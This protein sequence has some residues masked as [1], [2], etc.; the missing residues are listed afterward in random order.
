MD[1]AKTEKLHMCSMLT[2]RRTDDSP[3]P[4]GLVL[5]DNVLTFPSPVPADSGD[6]ICFSGSASITYSLVIQDPPTTSPT[7]STLPVDEG[8]QGRIWHPPSRLHDYCV[9]YMVWL[10]KLG[11]FTYRLI[12]LSQLQL[13]STGDSMKNCSQCCHDWQPEGFC[14]PSDIQRVR[15]VLQPF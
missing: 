8:G 13:A 9:C 1:H 11:K 7:T 12:N 4:D 2:C 14:E 6:Y 10:T 5:E 3:L 15:H